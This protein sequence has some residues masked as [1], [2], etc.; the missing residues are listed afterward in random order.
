MERETRRNASFEFVGWNHGSRAFFFL[1]LFFLLKDTQDVLFHTFPYLTSSYHQLFLSL[2][3]VLDPPLLKCKRTFDTSTT[4]DEPVQDRVSQLIT[5]AAA[6]SF[7]L[8][9]PTQQER[10]LRSKHRRK[11]T[12]EPSIH[13]TQPQP[14]LSSPLLPH[15][16]LP[17]S[18]LVLDS[19][20]LNNLPNDVVPLFKEGEPALKGSEFLLVEGGVVGRRVLGLG[21]EEE[22]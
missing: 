13:P 12:V 8:T 22:E 1:F 20:L 9:L 4:L 6:L 5:P 15:F 7:L 19:T 2:L 18:G 17:P 16:H 14:H 3:Y 21:R 10:K 11:T